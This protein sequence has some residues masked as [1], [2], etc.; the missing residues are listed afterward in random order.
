MKIIPFVHEGLGNSSYLVE[1]AGGEAALIDPDR[2]VQRYLREAEGRE[3]RIASIFET[4]LHA[5]FVSGAREAAHATGARLFVPA[6]ARSKLAHE[7]LRAGQRVNAGGA[8]IEAIASPGH[9]P[10]HLSYVLRA[11]RHEPALFSGGSLIVGGAARTD[12]IAPDMTERL[13]RD[14]FRTLKS[15]F[16]DLPDATLLYPTHGGG[17]FCSTGGGG[18]RTSTLGRERETNPLLAFQDEDEFVRWFP[19]TFPG[20]PAYFARM[21]GVNQ[22][23]PR[24]RSEIPEPPALD[25]AEFES[26]RQS[27]LVID[28]RP[29]EAYMAAHVPGSLSIAFRD[30]YATWLGWL[31]PP[32]KPLLFVTGDAQLE[33]VIDESLLVGYERFAGRLE[34]G[35]DEWTRAG[36]P[37]QRA[38][39]V[40]AAGARKALLNGAAALDVREPDEFAAGHIEGAHLAPLGGLL[41]RFDGLPKDRPVVAYCGHGERAATAVSLLERAGFDALLNLDGGVEAWE[42]EGYELATD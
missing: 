21:R 15:A 39:L 17:S 11:G 32:D 29:V 14:Q 36:L 34:G 7:P 10:E 8:E 5:D 41:T 25:P 31:L 9:T 33:R 24:L 3:L 6:G 1:L 35:I 16:T 13:T 40:G 30:A 19:T 37:V 23:G 18:Q 42:R 28:V 26:A 4:H 12:L 2:T 27:A 38:E 20:V 22:A